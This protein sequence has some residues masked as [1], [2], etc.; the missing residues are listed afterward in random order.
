MKAGI[1]VNRAAR[2]W[3]LGRSMM[4]INRVGVCVCEIVLI[5]IILRIKGSKYHD[6]K[7]VTL[8]Y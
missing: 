8:T 1:D 2:R 5:I 7:S 3:C 6:R 4:M